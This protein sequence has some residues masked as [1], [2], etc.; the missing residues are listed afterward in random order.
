MAKKF[1][2]SGFHFWVLAPLALLPLSL[3]AACAKTDANQT[4]TPGNG[5]T[6]SGTT[7]GSSS[8]TV[9][10]LVSQEVKRINQLNLT[11]KT[12]PNKLFSFTDVEKINA[13]NLL[14]EYVDGWVGANNFTYQISQL[15]KD[16]YNQKALSFIITVRNGNLIQD[17]QRFILA[18]PMQTYNAKTLI[19]SEVQ[20]LNN[21]N[22]KPIYVET[23]QEVDDT[24]WQTGAK[25]VL[26]R[27]ANQLNL[28]LNLFL[29]NVDDN[30]LKRDYKTGTMTFMIKV[31]INNLTSKTKQLS[32]RFVS[33]NQKFVNAAFQKEKQRLEGLASKLKLVKQQLTRDE[34]RDFKIDNLWDQFTGFEPNPNGQFVYE[35]DGLYKANN[36]IIQFQILPQWKE[37]AHQ[38][39][40]REPVTFQLAYQEI[41]KQTNN[42]VVTDYFTKTAQPITTGA[43]YLAKPGTGSESIIPSSQT[44]ATY[45]SPGIPENAQLM[46]GR[47]VNE[48]EQRQLKN[49]FSL[50]FQGPKDQYAFGTGWIL[51]YQL[52]DDPQTYPTTW[53]IATNAHVIQNLKVA[54]DVMSPE[55]YEPEIVDA[56]NNTLNLHMMTINNPQIDVQY[57][58][59][60]NWQQYLQA[61]IP[62]V[63]VRTVFIGNDFLT[64]SPRDFSTEANWA[65]KE[66][67]IDF[68]VLEVKFASPEEAR[69][70]TQNYVNEPERH[71]KYR[72]TSLLNENAQVLKD[73]Y[74]VI[75]F[76]VARDTT[77]YWRPVRLTS[78]RPK[79]LDP[80]QKQSFT[81]LS[82]SINYN[83]FTNKTGMFDAALGLS[84]FGYDYR[85]AYSLTTNYINWGLIYPVDYGSLGKGSSGS[86]LMDKE[87]YTM[88][89]HYAADFPA[90]TGFSIALYNEGFSY[91]GAFNKYNLEGYD[92]INGNVDGKFPNQRKSYRQSL[93]QLKGANFKT[94]LF[95]QGLDGPLKMA[96]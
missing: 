14:G 12:P 40:L 25:R 22:L 48:L 80:S 6:G 84:F 57:D 5:S 67:Y 27:L 83:S 45:P 65:S 52:S 70:M 13:T 96:S 78:S 7:G 60:N 79:N 91:N 89:I 41:T 46:S 56:Q 53:Y 69:Q 33:A 75:G 17:S 1:S 81:N 20:R 49:T 76:P 21:L 68:A 51:D 88:G 38:P 29:Y 74:S 59:S 18:L 24:L 63:N 43:N 39:W 26:K 62:A 32:F 77:T 15:T 50:G 4:N 73:G 87:G 93:K 28:N 42:E 2:K 72:Q 82:K 31:K 47:I 94:K 8:S 37:L 61:F 9:N 10:N 92:L 90:S 85:E 19:D 34:V 66:E 3:I 64:T 23:D 71:F 11:I 55:R 54:N 36:G 16:P 35:L 30:D 44:G 95:P 86:M 58:E